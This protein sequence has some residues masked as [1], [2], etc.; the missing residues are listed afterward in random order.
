MSK[1]NVPRWPSTS[2]DTQRLA[3]P[4]VFP[5]SKRTAPNRFLKAATSEHLASFDAVNVEKRGIPSPELIHL[6]SIFG[7]GGWGQILTGNIQISYTDLEGPG[8]A[9]IPPDAEFS[10]PRFEAFAALAAAGKS[11][12]SLIVGQ[13]SHP[14]RQAPEA[15]QPHPISASAVQLVTPGNG[16]FGVP[17][18]ATRQDLDNVIESFAHAAE[19]LERAGFDGIE[20]HGAHGYLLAQ[21]LS[22]VTNQRTDEYGGSL[23]NRMRLVLE[24]AA[25]VK[26]RVSERFVLGIKVNSVEFQEKGF[27]SEEAV[28]LC[29]ALEKAGFDYVETSGGTYEDFAFEHKKDSTKKRENY[30]VEF[31]ERIRKAVTQTKVYTTGGL[32]TV[33]GMNSTLEG[34]DGV[35]IGRA[36]IHEPLFAS[37]L[38]SGKITGAK[39]LALSE[40]DF[41][42][43][44]RLASYLI[45]LIGRGEDL[46][47]VTDPKVTEG[48]LAKMATPQ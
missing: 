41:P 8:N 30:F 4:I 44:L 47:D 1:V 12:G 19:Y 45:G 21:F 35:G 22:Q 27:T 36:G 10:G 16:P 13:V 37:D 14:G 43:Q 32:R 29:Q 23:E 34:V 5:Y 31:A 17:R 3:E 40:S 18:V 38:L 6:Y 11:N 42:G 7:K 46:P 2:T 15:L 39:K 20:L 26:K 9:I 24:V 33:G 28:A 48:I 25:A